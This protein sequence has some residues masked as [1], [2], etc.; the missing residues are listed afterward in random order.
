M[1][2][3]HFHYITNQP[4][5]PGFGGSTPVPL[6][7]RLPIFLETI[8]ALLSHLGIKHISLVSH[9]AGTHFALNL[10][11]YHRSLLSPTHPTLTLLSPWVHQSHTSVSSL[12]AASLLPNPMLNYWDNISGLI[13]NQI[14]PTFASSSGGLSAFAGVFGGKDGN[15]KKKKVEEEERKCEEGYGMSLS[16][17]KE[18][19]KM[20]WKYIFEENT[21][22]ANDEARLCLKSTEGCGWDACEDY[23]E[24]VKN[25]KQSWE[26]KTDGE[27]GK[28][29]LKVKIVLA[30]EDALVGKKGMEYFKECWTQEKCGRGIEVECVQTEGTDHDSILNPEKGFMQ[31]ILST[32]KE[33]EGSR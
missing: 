18:L 10:L 1:Q 20:M 21:K 30:E 19:D 6:S 15:E 28:G 7:S 29:K 11:H 4:L 16:V 3:N 2:P 33:N 25:L 17:K 22:G 14:S 23:P 8:T 5:R 26:Q 24:F 12:V 9:S 27:G 13:I 32:A 31:L